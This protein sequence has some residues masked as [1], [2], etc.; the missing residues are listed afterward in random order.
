MQGPWLL[1]HF[2]RFAWEGVIKVKTG[3]IPSGK[4]W[5]LTGP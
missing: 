5:L 1:A 2:Y 4:P 3:N